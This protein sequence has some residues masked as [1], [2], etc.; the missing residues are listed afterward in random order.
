MISGLAL[1][2]RLAGASMPVVRHVGREAATVVKIA[3][4]VQ[5]VG[6][7]EAVVSA[8]LAAA[9]DHHHRAVATMMIVTAIGMETGAVIAIGVIAAIETAPAAQTTAIAT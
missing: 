1:H 8:L 4:T 9:L 7:A 2:H 6:I 5:T 3:E